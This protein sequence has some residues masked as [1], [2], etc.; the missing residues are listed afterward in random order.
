MAPVLRHAGRFPPLNLDWQRLLLM[1][2]PAH[3]AVAD[4]EGLLKGLPNADVLLAVSEAVFSSRTEGIQTTI[5]EVLMFE[6]EGKLYDESTPERADVGEILNYRNAL[7]A[8]VDMLE[9]IPLSQRLIRD[10]HGILMQ[11]MRGRNKAPG[12]YWRVPD[13]CWH[14]GGFL[15]VGEVSEIARWSH[16]AEFKDLLSTP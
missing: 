8:A 12:Q 6:A 4:Y 5:T 13:S 14:P 11:G 9:E 1:I 2:G 15:L 7:F 3:A 16:P 10:T